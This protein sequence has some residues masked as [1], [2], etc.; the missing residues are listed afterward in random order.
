[1]PITTYAF[2]PPDTPDSIRT[3][4]TCSPT[5]TL[6]LSRFSIQRRC[7]LTFRFTPVT[8]RREY[9]VVLPVGASTIRFVFGDDNYKR[10]YTFAFSERTKIRVYSRIWSPFYTRNKSQY[11]N[12]SLRGRNVARFGAQPSDGFDFPGDGRQNFS[13]GTGRS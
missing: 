12:S 9:R 7:L 2:P 3:R 5:P 10:V 8:N 11:P 13:S 1:M 6:S 4:P